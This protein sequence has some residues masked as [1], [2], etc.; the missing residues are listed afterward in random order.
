MLPRPHGVT[1]SDTVEEDQE[2]KPLISGIA[3]EQLVSTE[4]N[5]TASRMEAVSQIE[6][7]IVDINQLFG[8]LSTLISEQGEQVQ[9]YV[10]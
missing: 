9:R 10:C 5:Y 2:R 7:H 1:V 6:S 8:R 4:Q 3:T